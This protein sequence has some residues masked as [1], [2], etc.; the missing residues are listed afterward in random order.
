MEAHRLQVSAIFVGAV[1]MKE[2]HDPLAVN[3]TGQPGK[4][5][6]R[7]NDTCQQQVPPADRSAKQGGSRQS[8]YTCKC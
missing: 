8:G 1:A 6:R 7:R 2:S 3:D 5:R 4:E